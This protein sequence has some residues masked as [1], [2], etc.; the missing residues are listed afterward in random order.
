[1]QDSTVRG[2]DRTQPHLYHNPTAYQ[3]KLSTLNIFYQ[4]EKQEM[5]EII[6]MVSWKYLVKE[7]EN[8]SDRQQWGEI[9]AAS[10]LS[11]RTNRA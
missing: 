5:L 3:M 2:I 4:T 8:V 1:M 7:P 11:T 10:L 6:N 9:E